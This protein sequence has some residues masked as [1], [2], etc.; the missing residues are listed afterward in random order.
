MLAVKQGHEVYG[1][2]KEHPGHLQVTKQVGAAEAA[3]QAEAEA[4]RRNKA[5]LDSVLASLQAAKKVNVLDKSRSDWK[6]YKTS[7][8]KVRLARPVC[9]CDARQHESSELQVITR[10]ICWA[11]FQRHAA[12]MAP[13]IQ[14]CHGI[15]VHLECSIAACLCPLWHKLKGDIQGCYPCRLIMSWRRIRRAMTSI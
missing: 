4:A 7:D 3:A 11:M 5:G 9:T 2:L 15:F 1:L 10:L 13:F 12:P 14:H 6:D 8:A